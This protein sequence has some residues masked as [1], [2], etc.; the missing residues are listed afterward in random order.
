MRRLCCQ[1]SGN[2]AGLRAD[3]RRRDCGVVRRGRRSGRCG[4]VCQA[5]GRA[6]ATAPTAS[7]SYSGAWPR[8]RSLH[9]GVACTAVL[10]ACALKRSGIRFSIPRGSA[11]GDA[12]G[13]GTRESECLPGRA[14]VVMKRL[15][16]H[17]L[18]LRRWS[19][20]L[21]CSDTRTELLGEIVCNRPL[22]WRWP[23]LLLRHRINPV[24][25]PR[26]GLRGSRWAARN[27]PRS[28]GRGRKWD[29][30]QTLLLPASAEK[31]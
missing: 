4:A 20:S 1:R 3:G 15:L 10:D 11:R 16:L 22:L 28:E 8:S 25:W 2:S 12:P 30:I 31:E 17:T 9:R 18:L 6:A 13:S 27:L 5:P 24:G 7:A 29:A 14:R 21:G 26:G 19:R 23:L